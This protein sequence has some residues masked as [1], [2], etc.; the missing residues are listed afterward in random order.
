MGPTDRQPSEITLF[1]FMKIIFQADKSTTI[2]T[3]NQFVTGNRLT[4]YMKIIG[5]TNMT[6]TQN[7]VVHQR[8][9]LIRLSIPVRHDLRSLHVF[10]HTPHTMLMTEIQAISRFIVTCQ[11]DKNRFPL[12]ILMNF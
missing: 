11:E 2:E 6:R 3:K 9:K 5:C 12:I 8:R 4:A 1:N 10:F 7:P